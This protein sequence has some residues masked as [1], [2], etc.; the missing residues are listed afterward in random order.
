MGCNTIQPPLQHRKSSLGCRPCPTTVHPVYFRVRFCLY[1]NIKQAEL[2]RNP[3]YIATQ[4]SLHCNSTFPFIHNTLATKRL[5]TS[6]RLRYLSQ[7][8]WRSRILKSERFSPNI[9]AKTLCINIIFLTFSAS[10]CPYTKKAKSSLPY[11]F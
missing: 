11:P 9:H 3:A 4:F 5:Q 7:T 2:V 10:F 6:F 8:Q 1:C